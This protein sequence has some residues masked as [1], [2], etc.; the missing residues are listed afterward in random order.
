M[1]LSIVAPFGRETV[2]FL[3]PEPEELNVMELPVPLIDKSLL[4]PPVIFPVPDKLFLMSNKL[5]EFT[6]NSLP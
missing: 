6:F 3:K 5:L 4:V 1:V 2:K